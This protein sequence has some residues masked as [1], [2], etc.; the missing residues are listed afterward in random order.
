MVAKRPL[1]TDCELEVETI[2]A[3]REG[4]IRRPFGKAE[5]ADGNVKILLLETEPQGLA[6][7]GEQ[8]EGAAGRP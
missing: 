5:S 8:R 6:G 2:P 3:A 1:F 4:E 7:S